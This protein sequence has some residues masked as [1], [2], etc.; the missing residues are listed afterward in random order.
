MAEPWSLR[1]LELEK[2]PT[3]FMVLRPWAA[4]DDMSSAE[5]RRSVGAARDTGLEE[6]VDGIS[7]SAPAG[8]KE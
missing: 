6:R 1:G 4:V 2:Q 8:R 7:E 3:F 5:S